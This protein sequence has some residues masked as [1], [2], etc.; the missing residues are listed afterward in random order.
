MKNNKLVPQ[1]IDQYISCFPTETQNLLAIMRLTIRNA[2]PQAMEIMSYQMPTFKYF[3]NLVHFA[4]YQHHIGFYPGPSGILEF[5][6]ELKNYKTSK[7]TV[8]FP[9]D[10]ALPTELIT[11]IVEFRVIQNVEKDSFKKK[12][13]T[14]ND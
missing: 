7:G 4:A 10:K 1:D 5:E 2:A 13:K 8:Q 6:S 14:N 12:K 9:L 11:R 3:G